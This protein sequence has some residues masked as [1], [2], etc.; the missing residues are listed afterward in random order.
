[1]W[2]R[3]KGSS[4]GRVE[5]SSRA[6]LATARPSCLS[7]C[8]TWRKQKQTTKGLCVREITQK[9]DFILLRI[10]HYNTTVPSAM[11]ICSGPLAMTP[12]TLPHLNQLAAM[13]RGKD[14]ATAWSRVREFTDRSSSESAMSRPV[15]RIGR[16]I[17]N[18]TARSAGRNGDG[19]I[20]RAI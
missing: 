16:R 5:G 20:R 7:P 19:C 4:P 2:A 14:V 17:G 10:T 6:V 12:K 3:R 9:C 18:E 11:E 8:I 13:T 1:M 15:R